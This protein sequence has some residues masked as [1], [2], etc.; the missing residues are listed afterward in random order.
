MEH[1]NI[2]KELGAVRLIGTFLEG[3]QGNPYQVK[4]AALN[5][6]AHL[7]YQ[8]SSVCAQVASESV[9][10]Q[11]L[12]DQLHALQGQHATHEMQ[13]LAAKCMTAIYRAD[14]MASDDPRLTFR[15]LPTL[16]ALCKKDKLYPLR[17]QA[18]EELAYLTEVNIT[19]QQTASI[20]DHL[21]TSLLDMLRLTSPLKKTDDQFVNNRPPPPPKS[22]SSHHVISDIE[23]LD[24]T[25][26]VSEEDF[27][28]EEEFVETDKL[29]LADLRAAAF[30]V[31]ASLASNDE[32]IRKRIIETDNLMSEV[33]VGID[34]TSIK[35]K[36]AALQ[37]LHSLSRS[38]QQLRTQFADHQ[39]W[40]PLRHMLQHSRFEVIMLSSSILCNL[41]LEFSPSKQVSTCS[42][43][44]PYILSL[45]NPN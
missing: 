33:M 10:G 29:V 40:L 5:W 21:I 43:L 16:I 13:F 14:A 24:C 19:L 25:E 35:V 45:S 36:L 9:A 4:L 28:T 30:K 23:M 31:F 37:C 12:L 20:C 17:S 18:A 41:L 42:N 27:E 8:N 3:D 26:E 6:L 32:D 11:T 34:D 39:V 15:T 44:Y 22:L 1:Q 38:V 7:C 2:M